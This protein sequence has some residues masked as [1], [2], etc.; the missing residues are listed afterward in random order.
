MLKA[1]AYSLDSLNIGLIL[2]A[3]LCAYGLPWQLIVLAYAV[4]GPAHYLTQLSWLYDRQFFTRQRYD[5]VYLVVLAVLILVSVRHFSQILLLT[6]FAAFAFAFFTDWMHRLLI[7]V[8]G[9]GCSLWLIHYPTWT[10]VLSF[11][12]TLIHVYLLTA[13][14]ML[15]GALKNRSPLGFVAV[16]LL[17]VCGLSFFNEVWQIRPMAMS[18]T[19]Y[20][21]SLYFRSIATDA[22]HFFHLSDND[23]QLLQWIRFI[24]FAYF[25]HYLNWF[26]KTRVIQWHTISAGRAALLVTLY[27]LS[28]S[29]YAYD[30]SLGF[31]ALIFLS[32]THVIL[33]FP[34]DFLM[35]KTNWKLCVASNS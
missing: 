27:L 29:L 10:V 32:F 3:W 2:F 25:Y 4:L 26:S 34:L 9:L 19:T 1:K 18:A 6:L 17:L 15:N 23:P 20:N 30:Y 12:P 13:L 5:Y 24:A 8:L 28:L 21:H 35:I 22:L 7:L 16:A 14:F 33:E 31:M 11:V